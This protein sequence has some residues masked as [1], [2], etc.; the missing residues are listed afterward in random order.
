MTL[1]WD[2]GLPM[3]LLFQVIFSWVIYAPPGLAG[4]LGAGALAAGAL[5]AWAL[6]AGALADWALPAGALADWALPA[7]PATLPSLIARS[8]SGSRNWRNASSVA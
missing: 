5:A 4:A 8:T 3:A 6:A 7:F 1:S 2:A